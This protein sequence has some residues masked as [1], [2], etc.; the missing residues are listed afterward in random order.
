MTGPTLPNINTLPSLP[1]SDC[2]Q[3][4]DTLF[5]PS[6]ALHALAEALLLQKTYT[7]YQALIDLVRGRLTALASSQT[8]EDRAILLNILGS[9]PRLGEKAA[10]SNAVTGEDAQEQDQQPLSELSRAEQENLNKGSAEQLRELN[11][12][13]E[14]KFPGLRF[15]YEDTITSD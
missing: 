4:L 12:E 9:H 7:S 6:Q 3:I 13:Y 15:V 1:P 14:E 11:Q 10:P 8:A 2:F 5:E